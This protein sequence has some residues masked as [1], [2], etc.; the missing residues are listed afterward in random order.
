MARRAADMTSITPDPETVPALGLR[1]NLAQ[2]SLL[3][4][5]TAFVGGMV[6]LERAILPLIAEREFGLVSKS[7]ILSF[8]VGFGF[9]KAFTNLAAGGSPTGSGGRDSLSPVGSSACPFP[10]C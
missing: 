8:I 2:F 5:V 1:Q 7:V 10:S 3:V 6:G 9:V 4:L